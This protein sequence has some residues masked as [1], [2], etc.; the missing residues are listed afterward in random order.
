MNADESVTQK[1]NK[2]KQLKKINQTFHPCMWKVCFYSLL[3]ST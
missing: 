1:G 3:S 2:R